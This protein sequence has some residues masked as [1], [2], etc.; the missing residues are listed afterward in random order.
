M[1]SALVIA[2]V[3]AAAPE[4]SSLETLRSGMGQRCVVS[5]VVERVAIGKGQ[6]QWE[7]TAVVLD[8]DT[9]IYVTY[10]APP[11]GWTVGTR[12]KVEGLLSPSIGDH[13]QSL[14]APHLRQPGTP[15]RDVQ[16]LSALVKRRVRLVG[17]AKNAKGGAVLLVEK[18]PVYVA[19]LAAWP[20]DALDAQVAVGG[21]LEQR[22]LLPEA[23]RNAKGEISQGTTG[24]STQL[25]M[26]APKWRVVNT[27]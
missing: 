1:V 26:D 25:V 16:K 21:Q 18:S 8:D 22:A 4:V 23:T 17:V 13:E 5:G 9:V 27:R 12:V 7:G 3:V 19:G 14:M 11:D 24:G 6:N 20:A 15:K 10:G 2:S